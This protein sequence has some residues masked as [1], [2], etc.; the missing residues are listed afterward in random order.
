MNCFCVVFEQLWDTIHVGIS[1]D[2]APWNSACGGAPYNN[3]YWLLLINIELI[4]KDH[5]Y[6]E[7]R[8]HLT[9]HSLNF[10]FSISFF[11]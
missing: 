3:L 10:L 4:Q 1:V 9:N 6:K 11:W 7:P 2:G 8:R 5:D